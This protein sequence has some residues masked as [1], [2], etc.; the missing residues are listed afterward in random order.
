MASVPRWI[1]QRNLGAVQ[2]PIPDSRVLEVKIR[3]LCLASL[4][5]WMTGSTENAEDFKCAI[6]GNDSP[7]ACSE[8]SQ[9][10]YFLYSQLSPWWQCPKEGR[11]GLLLAPSLSLFTLIHEE[12]LIWL[13]IA[14]I[15]VSLS[16][17]LKALSSPWAQ[18]KFPHIP[19][20]GYIV[21]SPYL[22]GCF[23]LGV[24]GEKVGWFKNPAGSPWGSRLGVLF[25]EVNRLVVSRHCVF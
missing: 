17:H 8:L 19:F 21:Q 5:S 22:N 20:H 13:F 10:I 18:W 2:N 6:S 15:F 16:F 23:V 3:L 25:A 14:L 1:L 12:Q 11:V 4:P 9:E 24:R 7:E